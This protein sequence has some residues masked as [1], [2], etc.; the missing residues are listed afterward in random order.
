[1]VVT[2][3]HYDSNKSKEMQILNRKSLIF[4]I[5]LPAN[6]SGNMKK[7]LQ[8]KGVTERYKACAQTYPQNKCINCGYLQ[9]CGGKQ[10]LLIFYAEQ[11]FNKI[12]ELVRFLFL[13][14]SLVPKM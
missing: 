3:C 8:I 13:L 2:A 9:R 4:I 12:M 11:Y 14:H 7:S 5:N 1:V 10:V 6:K